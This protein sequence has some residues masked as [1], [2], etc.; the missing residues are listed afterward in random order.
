M[1]GQP[2]LSGPWR[3]DE[4]HVPVD[5]RRAAITKGRHILAAEVLWYGEWAPAGMISPRPFF[6]APLRRWMPTA[7]A[8]EGFAS[9]GRR[10]RT[11]PSGTMPATIACD[12]AR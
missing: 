8:W 2:T 9:H 7:A 10:D 5:E 6:C 11:P 12:G 3:G 4:F 1:D